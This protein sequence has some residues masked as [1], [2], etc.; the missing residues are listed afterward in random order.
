MVMASG[1]CVLVSV[2]VLD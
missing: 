2:D 1:M